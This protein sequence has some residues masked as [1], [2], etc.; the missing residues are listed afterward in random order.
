[1]RISVLN[2]THGLIPDEEVQAAIR[3]VNRQIAEDFAPYWSVTGRLRLEGASTS[4]PDS[5]NPVDMQGEAIVY[6]WDECNVANA[7]GYHEANHR[8]IPCGFVFIEIATELGEP[9]TV[10]FSHEVL[11]MLGDRE[12]NLLV[13]GP[14]PDPAEHGREVYHWREMC[15]AVQDDSYLIDNVRVSNFVLPLYFTEHLEAGHRN[16]FLGARG[17]KSFGVNPGGYIGFY[18]PKLGSHETWS[19]ESKTDIHGRPV[20][21]RRL[22]YKDKAR[23]VRRGNRY[24]GLT[25]K[26]P[27]NIV[28]LT[29][30]RARK[31]ALSSTDISIKSNRAI[32]LNTAVPPLSQSPE[33]RGYFAYDI[34]ADS[35]FVDSEIKDSDFDEIGA[36]EILH[37]DAAAT[38]TIDV[39]HAED[40]RVIALVE[41]NGVLLAKAPKSGK[42]KS[43]FEIRVRASGDAERR[44]S[45][46]GDISKTVVRFLKH[47]LSDVVGK[48]LKEDLPDLLARL[49]EKALFHKS[50]PGKIQELVLLD[51]PLNGSLAKFQD[52][53]GDLKPRGHYLLLIHGIFSSPS[54][55]FHELLLSRDNDDMPKMLAGHYD[56]IIA[57]DHW[58]VAKD[59]LQ[60][61][62]ELTALLP[63]GCTV[64]IVCHSRG[65][66][67]TRCLLEHPELRDAVNSK[68]IK[69]R[70]VMFVAGANQ[71]SPLASP[72]RID[73]LVNVFSI[74]SSVTT[75]YFPFV[76]LATLLL[77]AVQ[78]GVKRF[79]GIEAMSPQSPILTALDKPVNQLD[80]EYIYM[81]SNYEPEGE[82]LKL[83][84]EAGIDEYVFHGRRN[85]AVV[86]F[87]G[88]GKFD[89]HVVATIKVEAGPQFGVKKSGHVFHT[90]FFKQRAVR[91]SLLEQ[92]RGI[93][94]TEVPASNS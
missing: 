62:T 47:T 3:A 33:R 35:G 79:P 51:S 73:V 80:A 39:D 85:D 7:L 38:L 8:G 82:L 57:F 34:R 30:S 13:Q 59:T 31:L 67:V 42:G 66:G 43:T 44:G 25:A 9:W 81:R 10:T 21:G 45:L 49:V 12:A 40:E 18:D 14:H 94:T 70:K 29:K 17:L 63:K 20:S 41:I 1:M 60:N 88:A 75:A 71:G 6:L 91:D 23:Q 5:D 86:P 22:E 11:E 93:G 54:G 36:I 76:K 61:A 65:A 52:L 58:T 46:L 24:S 78:Y 68:N 89:K 4:Q 27:E 37:G 48:A 15:D 64:D 56:K 87:T 83:L 32:A 53:K 69:A 55:A 77:K 92:L 74:L 72:N 84:D 19:D 16:D 2:I 50:Q 26:S 90:E 28:R